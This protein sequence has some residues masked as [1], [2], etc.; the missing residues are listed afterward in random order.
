MSKALPNPS[1]LRNSHD[2][3]EMNVDKV[4]AAEDSRYDAMTD[5]KRE[6]YDVN[7]TLRTR[8]A[9]RFKRS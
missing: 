4:V 8:V 5:A 1:Q 2:L 3:E 7:P 9:K 6:T